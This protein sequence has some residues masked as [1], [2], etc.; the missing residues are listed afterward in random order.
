M[1]IH[2]GNEVAF[3]SSMARERELS[4]GERN[5]PNGSAAPFGKIEREAAPT[6]AHVENPVTRLDEQLCRN[7]ALL[8]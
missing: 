1:E 2:A 8:G 3:C 4:L 7:M 5:P 6:A